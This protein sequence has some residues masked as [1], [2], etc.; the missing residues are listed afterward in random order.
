VAGPRPRRCCCPPGAPPCPEE[1]RLQPVQV[2]AGART[3][4]SLPRAARAVHRRGGS[5]SSRTGPRLC[6]RLAFPTRGPNNTKAQPPRRGR[7][8]AAAAAGQQLVKPW[9]PRRPRRSRWPRQPRRPWCLRWPRRNLWH[10]R[11]LRSLQRHARSLD[12][13]PV[14]PGVQWR[15]RRRGRQGWERMLSDAA[16]KERRS[17]ELVPSLL[18]EPTRW[19]PR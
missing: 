5:T 14:A 19:N 15:R 6:D 3:A 8:R 4:G 9:R 17:R 16:R 18:I 1:R 7:G 2:R 11:C 13:P 12:C 10:L